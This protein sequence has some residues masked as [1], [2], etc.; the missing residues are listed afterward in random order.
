MHFRTTLSNEE[1]MSYSCFSSKGLV[2]NF[3]RTHKSTY[4]A[5]S[6]FI[7]RTVGLFDQINGFLKRMYKKCHFNPPNVF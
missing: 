7:E 6:S 2:G 3:H 5:N 4:N 1:C